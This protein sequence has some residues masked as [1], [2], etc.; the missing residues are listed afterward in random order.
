MEHFSLSSDLF[1]TS[2]P[3]F[4]FVVRASSVFFFVLILL[5]LAGKRQLAQMSP[6]EFVAILLISNAVQNSMNGGDNS[7]LGG[8]VLAIVLIA[9]STLISYLTYRSRHFRHVFEGTPTLLIHKGLII[10]KNLR[11]ER[12]SHS[13]L[14]TILRRQN[15]HHKDE[16]AEA[17]L[18]PDGSFTVILNSDK[19]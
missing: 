1:H 13:E 11:R 17:I 12:I 18:E 6:T 7:L 2:I 9:C 16:V 10:E 15:V 4:D 14:T 5:R 8:F 3:I 19:T